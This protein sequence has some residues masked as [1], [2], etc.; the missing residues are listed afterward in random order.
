MK[1]NEWDVILRKKRKR[2]QEGK[3]SAFRLRGT[4][5][6]SMRVVR[7]EKRRR[8]GDQSRLAEAGM[9]TIADVTSSVE[10]TDWY[11]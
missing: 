2:E 10:N 3:E 7:E 9:C 1:S 6:D 8:L 11:S 4:R 5:V